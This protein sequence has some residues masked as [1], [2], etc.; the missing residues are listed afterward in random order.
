MELLGL[1]VEIE[2]RHCRGLKGNFKFKGR[3]RCC[4]F[5]R[6]DELFGNVYNFVC[7]R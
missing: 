1:T 4:G 3:I 7:L 6:A 2:T 5:P